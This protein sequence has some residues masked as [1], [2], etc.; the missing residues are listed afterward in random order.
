[1]WMTTPCVG[2]P[3]ARV[4]MEVPRVFPSV[5][6]QPPDAIDS[7]GLELVASKL[8]APVPRAGLLPRASLQSL[9]EIGLGAKLCLVDAPAGCG[10]TTLL[11]QWQAVSGGG[12]VAWVS[13]DD[14]EK[15]PTRLWVSVVWA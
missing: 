9:L 14:G 3:G 15:G 1:M 7:P 13:L 5:Q 4:V 10:K 6:D 8:A 11:A 2:R 12:R